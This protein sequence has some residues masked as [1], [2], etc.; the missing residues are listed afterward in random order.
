MNNR[1]KRKTKTMRHTCSTCAHDGCCDG[2]PRCGGSC[3]VSAFSKCDRCGCEFRDDGDW[4]SDD[5]EHSFCCEECLNEWC[6]E[7]PNEEEAE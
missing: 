3:W 5:G 4:Q 2:L 7:H 1:K 6:E